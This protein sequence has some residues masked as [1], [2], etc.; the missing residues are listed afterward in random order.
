MRGDR[1]KAQWPGVLDEAPMLL[2]QQEFQHSV[3]EFL[4]N[5][6]HRIVLL[7]LEHHGFSVWE[8]TRKARDG[9]LQIG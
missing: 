2:A 8:G 9:E 3:S 4:G 5:R 6:V 7:A 1:T